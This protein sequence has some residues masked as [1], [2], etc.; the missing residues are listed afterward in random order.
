MFRIA[1]YYMLL[2]K[3][4]SFNKFLNYLDCKWVKLQQSFTS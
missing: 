2:Q 4:E 1:I 3:E